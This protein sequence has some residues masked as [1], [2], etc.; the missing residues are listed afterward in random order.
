MEENKQEDIE[1]NVLSQNMHNLSLHEEPAPLAKLPL[2]TTVS[3]F[4][5][6]LTTEQEMTP[7]I[8]D[9]FVDCNSEYHISEKDSLSAISSDGEFN[10]AVKI[11]VLQEDDSYIDR[12]E[13][14]KDKEVLRD[15]IYNGFCYVDKPYQK[16]F[17]Q[18]KAFSHR[19]ESVPLMT[20]TEKRPKTKRDKCLK[21]FNKVGYTRNRLKPIPRWCTDMLLLDR[22]VRYQQHNPETYNPDQIFGNFNP[23]CLQ[24]SLNELFGPPKQNYK[25]ALR[26]N[27]RGSSAIWNDDQEFQ[28]PI[29]TSK[30]ANIAH[31]NQAQVLSV[32]PFGVQKNVYGGF[33]F[34]NQENRMGFPKIHMAA[35]SIAEERESFES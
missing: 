32:S 4:Q 16:H 29:D 11:T 35:N 24:L 34:N 30:L 10:D 13:Q 18:L 20:S 28:T 9:E 3:Q 19:K 5:Q 14:I 15:N 31:D 6:Y 26:F 17:K 27:R 8:F 21:Y 2:T 22:M 25:K 12:I 1:I 33:Q 23:K 7:L